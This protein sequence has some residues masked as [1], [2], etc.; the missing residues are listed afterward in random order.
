MRVAHYEKFHVVRERNKE[1]LI[2]Q[3]LLTKPTLPGLL[4]CCSGTELLLFVGMRC[5]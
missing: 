3:G 5:I 4:L 1:L 2:E